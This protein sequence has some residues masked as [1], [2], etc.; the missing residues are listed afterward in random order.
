MKYLENVCFVSQARL[1]SKRFPRKMI[2]SFANSNL[3]EILCEKINRSLVIPREQFFF[4][5]YEEELIEVVQRCRLNVFRRSKRS[6]ESEGP[7]E[8]ILDWKRL[9]YDF[10]VQISACNPLLTINTIDSFARAF[11]ESDHQSLFAVVE[12]RNYFWNSEGELLTSWPGS[13]FLDTK[14]VGVTYEA[15][16][17]LYA[18]RMDLLR[19]GIWMGETPFRKNAPALFP[20]PEVEAFDIDYPWQLQVAEALYRSTLIP[21]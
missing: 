15:A 21:S 12:K 17:C 9:P 11:M 19:K 20:I 4:S 5:V 1:E 8:E 6:A 10:A 3:V 13:N 7:I 2:A 14:A 18:G 16:H